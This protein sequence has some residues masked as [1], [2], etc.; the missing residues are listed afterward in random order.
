M[1]IL[2]CI[3]TTITINMPKLYFPEKEKEKCI[4]E[5]A[6][7]AIL[8]FYY[9]DIS[10]LCFF[11]RYTLYICNPLDNTWIYHTELTTRVHALLFPC[12]TQE[13]VC[14]L[15]IDFKHICTCMYVGTRIQE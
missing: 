2:C 11:H 4:K 1:F 13:A 5:K 8:L 12:E 14:T 9:S 3:N 7:Y 6:I 15:N 10:C